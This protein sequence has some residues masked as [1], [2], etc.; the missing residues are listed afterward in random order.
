MNH[1]FLLILIGQYLYGWMFPQK[2]TID[3]H[4]TLFARTQIFHLNGCHKNLFAFYGQSLGGIGDTHLFHNHG[5]TSSMQGS[6]WI[7]MFRR[8]KKG[9]Q[10]LGGIVVVSRSNT[11]VF[12]IL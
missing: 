9:C 11:T 5:V 4:G 10:R 2:F 3:I 12:M 6:K 1:L 7:G 8:D